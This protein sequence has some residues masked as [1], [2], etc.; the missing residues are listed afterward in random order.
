VFLALYSPHPTPTAFQ[1]KPKRYPKLTLNVNTAVLASG[2]GKKASCSQV[3]PTQAQV[4]K[5]WKDW[6]HEFNFKLNFKLCKMGSIVTT[7]VFFCFVVFLGSWELC[8]CVC[9]CV[10][11]IVLVISFLFIRN[12][13]PHQINLP[14]SSSILW[15]R[16][17]RGSPLSVFSFMFYQEKE[18]VNVIPGTGTNH[19]QKM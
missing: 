5:K 4:R 12:S 2:T 9:A 16:E 1:S 19:E 7:P 18:R 6:E 15:G 3:P 11:V 14:A 17:K 13:L 10:C 8:V